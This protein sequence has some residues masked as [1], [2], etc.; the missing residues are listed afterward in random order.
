M[1]AI[2]PAGKSPKVGVNSTRIRPALLAENYEKS[3]A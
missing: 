2:S 3:A 1:P